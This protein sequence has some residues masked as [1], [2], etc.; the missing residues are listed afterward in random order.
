[1]SGLQITIGAATGT[2]WMALIVPGAIAGVSTLIGIGLTN[3]SLAKHRKAD[4]DHEAAE[5]RRRERVGAETEARDRALTGLEYAHHLE[6]YAFDSANTL[7]DARRVNWNDQVIMPNLATFNPWPAIIDWRLLGP[8]TAAWARHFEMKVEQTK[9]WLAASW[10]DGDPMSYC[11]DVAEQSALLGRDAWLEAETLR[12]QLG[13]EPF[14]FEDRAWDFVTYLAEQA[15][16]ARR[17]QRENAARLAAAMAKAAP[18][19]V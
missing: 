1:M 7:D 8:K 6:R 9:G 13:L 14:R 15:E 3:W 10:E 17:R 12:R 4:R 16:E 18:E 5:Q 2:N 19:A 11:D